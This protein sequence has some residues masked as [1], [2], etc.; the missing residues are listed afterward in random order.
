MKLSISERN[1]VLNILPREGTFDTLITLRRF[2]ESL[3]LS[4]EEKSQVRWRL[5]YKCPKC[6]GVAFLP[7]PAQCGVCDVW[8]DATGAAQWNTKDD[9]N[10]EIVLP[11]TIKGIIIGILSKLNEKGKLTEE[12][13]PAYEKFL[14]VEEGGSV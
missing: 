8:M 9:P 11:Q 14:A 3:S 1:I 4:E 5:E 13:L 6:N 2:K 12:L 7:E 10:K